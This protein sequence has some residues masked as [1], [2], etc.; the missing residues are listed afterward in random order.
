MFAH[1]S[2]DVTTCAAE[3]C[4][5]YTIDGPS[6]AVE[7]RKVTGG[8]GG[9]GRKMPTVFFWIGSVNGKQPVV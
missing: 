6:D 8:G 2:S 5:D 9:G 7:K 3:L 4:R 1:I